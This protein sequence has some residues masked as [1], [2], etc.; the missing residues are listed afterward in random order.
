MCSL[1]SIRWGPEND[2]PSLKVGKGCHWNSC[3]L[4]EV[5]LTADRL[6]EVIYGRLMGVLCP[7]G[8]SPVENKTF[9]V[10]CQFS[11]P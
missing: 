3:G 6:A 10:V 2:L 8:L 9:S 5:L 1:E 4:L 11:L 7:V